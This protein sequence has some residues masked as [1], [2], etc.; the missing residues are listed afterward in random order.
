MK[1]PNVE[2]YIGS[3]R[4][5]KRDS[6]HPDEPAGLPLAGFSFY[7]VLF[8]FTNLFYNFVALFYSIAAKRIV[9]WRLQL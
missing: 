7:S 8:A 5:Y 4:R 6:V 1:F 2:M 9:T 3:K